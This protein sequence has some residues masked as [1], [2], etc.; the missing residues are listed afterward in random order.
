MS[1]RRLVEYVADIQR[2]CR[3]QATQ[4]EARQ[5]FQDAVNA[6]DASA[7]WEF[8]IATQMIR[9]YAPY[10][11]G[12][13]SCAAGN[14]AV[15]LTGGSWTGS[16]LATQEF[17]E[18]KFGSRQMPY[19]LASMP[20]STSAVLQNPISGDAYSSATDLVND[21]YVLYQARYPLPTDCE[22]GRDLSLKGPNGTGNGDGNIPKVQRLIYDR[23]TSATRSGGWNGTFYTDDELLAA[24]FSPSFSSSG[25]A[26]PA[27]IR[28]EPYPT[29]DAE[30]RLTYYKTLRVPDSSNELMSIPS[31]FERAPIL[32][33]A[34]N[35]LRKKNMQ[36]W[37]VMRQEAGDMLKKMY[38]RYASSPA[39][40]GKIDPSYAD[41][42]DDGD[43]MFGSDSLMYT[44]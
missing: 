4:Y 1:R 26:G 16:S 30:Y 23:R 3:G 42:W 2:E 17:R 22:P 12:T 24:G 10:S 31:A 8:L 20:S 35:I 13:V 19:K 40:E 25:A 34:A 38:S 36:G 28:I 32:A 7:N 15:T 41:L 37:Q 5:A 14:T 44:R 18:I 39:Y 11:T 29:A 33:A 27:T 43:T 9:V 21:T 6:I